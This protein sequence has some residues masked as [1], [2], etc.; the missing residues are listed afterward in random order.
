MGESLRSAL[1]VEVMAKE[2]FP[3]EEVDRQGWRHERG[4]RGTMKDRV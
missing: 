2:D 3:K 4:R 1:Q